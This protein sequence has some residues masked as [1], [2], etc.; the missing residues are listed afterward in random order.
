M[1]EIATFV[2]LKAS[3]V[4]TILVR[5]ITLG[6]FSGISLVVLLLGSFSYLNPL[7]YAPLAWFLLTFPFKI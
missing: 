7:F 4:R 2:E 5:R 6:V 3:V 1:A